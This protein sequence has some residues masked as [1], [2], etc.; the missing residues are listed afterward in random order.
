[1][2]LHLLSHALA[3]TLVSTLL[4]HAGSQVANLLAACMQM[5]V[6]RSQGVGQAHQL[7]CCLVHVEAHSILV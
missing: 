7:I 3:N 2:N 1:M 6:H 5:Q 4:L